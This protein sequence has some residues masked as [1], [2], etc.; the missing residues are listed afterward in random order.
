MKV[1]LI[2]ILAVTAYLLFYFQSS[3]HVSPVY[4]FQYFDRLKHLAVA[5]IYGLTDESISEV[6]KNLP[7][8]AHL[9]IQGCWRV[10]DKVCIATQ[11]R[12]HYCLVCHESQKYSLHHMA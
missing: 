8:L 6:A 2:P 9:N 1:S 5:K 11:W 12:H 4:T 10:T 7:E 3:D